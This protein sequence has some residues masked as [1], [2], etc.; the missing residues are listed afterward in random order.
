MAVACGGDLV[1]WDLIRGD[2]KDRFLKLYGSF[3]ANSLYNAWYA[4]VL[5]GTLPNNQRPFPNFYVTIVQKISCWCHY[6]AKSYS[7]LLKF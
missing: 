7:L 3:A 4:H 2:V 1:V 5:F 6:D